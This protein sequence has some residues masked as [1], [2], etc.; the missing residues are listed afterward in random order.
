MTI[1]QRRNQIKERNAILILIMLQ[2]LWIVPCG[3]KYRKDYVE[4]RQVKEITISEISNCAG[5]HASINSEVVT[6][7]DNDIPTTQSESNSIGTFKLT[8]YCSCKKCTTDGDGITASG[9]VATQGRTIAVDP[10]VI[11]YGTVVIINGREYVAEDSGGKWIQGNEID[12]FFV[13]HEEAIAF[14][15]Q[16][17]EIFIKENSTTADQS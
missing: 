3:Y 14:G 1:K 2:L 13:N 10:D 11:P 7:A 8:A 4:P 17:A 9:T 16:Y 15:I 5:V 12:I 6:V